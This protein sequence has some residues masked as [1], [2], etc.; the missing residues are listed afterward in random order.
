MGRNASLRAAQARAD[1][2]V[3]RLAHC[4]DIFFLPLQP[5]LFAGERPVAA[6][7]RARGGDDMHLA[8]PD[9]VDP[10]EE[11]LIVRRRHQR[12][13]G[14]ERSLIRVAGHRGERPQPRGHRREGEEAAGAVVVKR[15]LA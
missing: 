7:G 15:T 11:A 2:A 4:F 9:A 6:Q 8:G 10:A 14:N 1:S 13:E 3:E 12:Q 5:Q